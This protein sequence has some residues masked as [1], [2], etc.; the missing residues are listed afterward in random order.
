MFFNTLEVAK[1]RAI[2]L[3]RFRPVLN[4][5]AVDEEP[6]SATITIESPDKSYTIVNAQ[7]MT[8]NET[9]EYL[10]YL[11]DTTDTDKWKPSEYKYWPCDFWYNVTID[12][13]AVEGGEVYREK[14]ILAVVGDVWR[15]NVA[16]Q[17]LTVTDEGLGVFVAEDDL[18]SLIQESIGSVFQ[19]LSARR[20][21]ISPGMILNRQALDNYVLYR[22]L[23][24]FW[25][26]RGVEK[27]QYQANNLSIHYGK[28]SGEAWNDALQTAHVDIDNDGIINEAPR[29]LNSMDLRP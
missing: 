1:D 15:C 5:L 28:L 2:Q 10:E 11:L 23:E 26:R 29:Q 13:Q 6:E 3:Y 22:S 7:D 27:D 12:W 18:V 14:R 16:A 21:A 4:G 24:N 19:R 8:W 20:P 17:D 9:G 25:G